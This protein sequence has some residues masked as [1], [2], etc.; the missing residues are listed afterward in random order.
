MG[1][2]ALHLA[3]KL[4]NADACAYLLNA[5]GNPLGDK[6]PV[7]LVG[8]TPA[9]CS[10]LAESTGKQ[11]AEET[12]KRYALRSLLFRP[13]DPGILPFEAAQARSGGTVEFGL[14]DAPGWRVVMEDAHCV[15][16]PVPDAPHWALFGL[17][18][19]HGGSFTG[20]YAANHLLNIFCKTDAW[21]AKTSQVQ[22][23]AEGLTT[24]FGE[25]DKQLSVVPRMMWNGSAETTFDTSGA[26]ALAC[27]VTP[28]HVL[29]ANCGDSR[30]VL[31]QSEGGE[32]HAAPLSHDQ[33]PDNPAER[34]R[35][36]AAGAR[37]E[38]G[39]VNGNLAV[40]RAIGD[41][42]FKQSPGPPSEQ[43]VCAV[44][45]VSVHERTKKDQCVLL[46]C[47]GVYDVMSNEEIAAFLHPLLSDM[48]PVT[49][50]AASYALVQ[51][52]LKLNSGDNM[53]AILVN[54][55]L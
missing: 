33:K 10:A 31:F 44:P 41:F 1:R 11:S 6:A 3:A 21:H 15:Y 39:R 38:N 23:L 37:V 35:I 9:A 49:L 2:T 8:Y 28:T 36:E 24:T 42:Q 16:S 50:A 14:Y 45:E 40:A 29:V 43:P 19:G 32:W 52:C 25:L 5:M 7:D 51:N 53:S 13:G 46:A 12:E 4:G 47:D 48:K 27:L 54:A 17:F 20:K 18:D 26:T 30:A 55:R 22:V 34:A